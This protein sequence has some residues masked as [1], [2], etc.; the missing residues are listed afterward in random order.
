MKK[1]FLVVLIVLCCFSS[2]FAE[3]VKT[4]AIDP[5]G[6]AMYGAL[7]KPYNPT[8]PRRLAMGNA[9]LAAVNGSDSLFYNP[10]GL[11]DRKVVVQLPSVAF[12][13]YH[14]YGMIQNGVIDDIKNMQAGDEDAKT[15]LALHLKKALGNNY[16]KIAD[17]DASVGFSAGGFGLAVNVKDT[18][19]SYRVSSSDGG[20]FDSLNASIALGYGQR[21]SIASNLSIDLGAA[22]RFNYLAYSGPVSLTEV[23]DKMENPE[24]LLNQTPIMAGYSIPVD[25]GVGLNL[26]L[27]FKL[28]VVA[29]NIN[30]KMHMNS[31]ENYEDALQNPLGASA[32]SE[33]FTFDTDFSLDAGFAWSLK[34]SFFSPTI[35]VDVV[36]TIGIFKNKNGF[37]MRDLMSHLSAGAEVR[38]LYV[39]D[40]RGGFNQ[41]YWTLGA[42]LD[43]WAIKMDVAYFWQ[44]LG[45]T[46]GANPVDGLTVK[47]NIGW[48]R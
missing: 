30:G 10:A 4:P 28:A 32:K 24:E 27:N 31:Y 8:S 43:L 44:E 6:S 7:L 19:H 45:K 47:F 36:D 38:V 46:A 33:S 20:V 14:P 23:L 16:T 1:L 48:D 37:E 21:I 2:L 26:P 12:T 17:V 40:V 13:L 35:A 22:V 11:A 18:V 41:G 3:E 42:G 15:D 25:I 29:R 39:L 5:T 9:G 34:N